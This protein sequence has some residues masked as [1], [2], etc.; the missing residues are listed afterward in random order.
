VSWAASGEKKS[1]AFD[2]ADNGV[3]QFMT[4]DSVSQFVERPRPGSGPPPRC[5]FDGQV[6]AGRIGREAKHFQIAIGLEEVKLHGPQSTIWTK[7]L[8]DPRPVVVAGV[9][10]AKCRNALSDIGPSFTFSCVAVRN[11]A[12]TPAIP[13]KQRGDTICRPAVVPPTG[14]ANYQD[15]RI[16]AWCA[17]LALG[18]GAAESAAAVG[19]RMRD[20]FEAGIAA[21]YRPFAGCG[22]ARGHSELDRRITSHGAPVFVRGVGPAS[23]VDKASTR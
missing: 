22:V 13:R 15:R 12:A 5:Q 23:R 9:F 19:G 3:S 11:T 2:R 17:C 16:S 1:I 10:P 7:N 14:N 21:C 8:R 18:V 6:T 20:C 4:R